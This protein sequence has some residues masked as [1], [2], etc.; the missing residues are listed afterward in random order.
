MI[1]T[2]EPGLSWICSNNNPEWFLTWR[3]WNR[4]G[5]ALRMP[6]RQLT[7]FVYAMQRVPESGVGPV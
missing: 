1:L 5:K 6:T 3:D 7:G 4:L 2:A